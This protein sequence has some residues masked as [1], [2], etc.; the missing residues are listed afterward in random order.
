MDVSFIPLD[1]DYV[2]DKS[3]VTW[4]RLFG[5][6]NNGKSICVFDSCDSFFYLIP[7]AHVNLE[8]YAEG[9]KKVKVEIANRIGAVKKVEIVKKNFLGQE[10]KALKVYVE[11]H[12][13][14]IPI[15]DIVKNFPETE[16]KEE[17]DINFVTRYLLEKNLRPLVWHNVEGQELDKKELYVNDIEPPD[18]DI[19]FK[20]KTIKLSD[21][22]HD[23]FPKI[24][25]F[26]IESTEIEM[27]KGQ[28][29]MI[30][31]ANDKI[32][33][34]FTWK[35]FNNAPSEV[36]FVKSERELIEKFKEIVQKEKPDFL[37][38]YF[39]DGFDL[40]Y[41]RDRADELKVKLDIGLD[42]GNITFV[43]GIVSSAKIPGIVHIDI[44]KFVENIIS[45]TL[46]S[47]TLTLNEV[48]KELVGDEKLKFDL[49][50]INKEIQ[51]T[52]GK[53]ADAEMRKYCLY[54]LQDSVL[55]SKL[56]Y[57]LWPNISE[58]T[59]IVGEP[60]WVTSRSSYSGLVEHHI[61]HHLEPFNEIIK[62]RPVHEEIGKRRMKG[63]YAGAFVLE[64]K[65][66]LYENLAVFDFRSIYPS[67]IVSFNISASTILNKPEKNAYV[68]PEFELD[69]K[70]VKF[71][72]KKERGFFPE[73]LLNLVTY[74]RKVKEELRKNRTPVLEARDYALK[75]LSNA[76]YGYLG[77]FGARWYC[78]EC[79]ASTAAT[80]RYYLMRTIEDARKTG[81]NVIYGDT[82]SIMLDMTGKTQAEALKW[83]DKI[84]KSLPGAM[85]LELEAFY[86]RGIFVMT[87]KKEI[88]AKKK[89]A[90]LGK[91]DRLKIRGF[92]TVR[93]DWAKLTKELQDKVLRMI[94][95]E[96]KANNALKY[97]QQ[98]IKDLKAKKIEKDKLVIRTQLKKEIEEYA[99]ITPHVTIARRMQELGLPVKIG[100]LIEYIVTEEKHKKEG[101]GKGKALVRERAKLPEETSEKEYDADY[102]IDHQI[103]PAV[104]NI[105]E[106]FG[107]SKEQI[108][109]KE[110]KRLVEF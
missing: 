73:I 9:V 31:V 67:V 76:T 103:L 37:V 8:K 46:Q 77:F 18:V 60:L 51:A 11:N 59:K 13:D 56:F 98:I 102:Y 84:N 92:E 74:R 80:A 47:E 79:A 104:E 64:P 96:G 72:F 70:K 17:T 87:R 21:K 40:P 33:K 89:Y 34:V 69:R 39:S 4:I 19:L 22:Q 43:R 65:P 20:A 42:S 41:L 108:I 15:K 105:F 24:L 66:G 1:M 10:I 99:A 100:T 63:K 14:I 81:F 85:E 3:G 110:Q 48:A 71:Y 52:K 97:V 5:K 83:H 57:Q 49:N 61:I 30:S 26:D 101:K 78:R 68:T 86:K 38:G 27:G 88:G 53:I 32:R 50:K 75:T 45:P 35:H 7:K 109:S 44:F 62:N 82:D 90:L 94:L 58:L 12:K 25:A 107:I 95:D 54:N 23:F 29:L 28:V 55:A 93:R 106:V 6:T 91:D 36:E 16:E 2:D